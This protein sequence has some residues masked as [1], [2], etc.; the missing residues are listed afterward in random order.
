AAA[1]PRPDRGGG[2]AAG[3]PSRRRPPARVG[4]PRGTPPPPHPPRAER[5]GRGANRAPTPPVSLLAHPATCK[6]G[7]AGGRYPLLRRRVPPPALTAGGRP[8][9]RAYKG[10]RVTRERYARPPDAAGP[11]RAA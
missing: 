1:R 9:G 4:P 8:T 10:R 11:D 6:P 7:A 3:P 2:S 5:G